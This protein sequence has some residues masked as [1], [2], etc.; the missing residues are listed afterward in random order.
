MDNE[1]TEKLTR[2]YFVFPSWGD[3]RFKWEDLPRLFLLPEKYG[4][5]TEMHQLEALG[6][7]VSKDDHE[8]ANGPLGGGVII[9][10]RDTQRW[11]PMELLRTECTFKP[12]PGFSPFH[13]CRCFI[14]APRMRPEHKLGV[15]PIPPAPSPL[16]SFEPITDDDSS[17]SIALGFSD[18]IAAVSRGLPT[19]ATAPGVSVERLDIPPGPAAEPFLRI[20]NARLTYCWYSIKR[21]DV[22]CRIWMAMIISFGLSL[23]ERLNGALRVVHTFSSTFIPGIEY[24]TATKWSSIA[25]TIRTA[26]DW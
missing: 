20:R 21:R 1:R 14:L 4:T 24:P 23:A 15:L 6:Y 9:V 17:C 2:H 7:T 13:D 16:F 5:E 22:Q 11:F 18:Q 19:S 12:P 26:S 8:F 10:K 3:Y 25:K